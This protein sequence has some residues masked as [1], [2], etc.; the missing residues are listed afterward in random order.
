MQQSEQG[1]AITE[2]RGKKYWTD[3]RGSL[4]PDEVV[5]PADKLEDETVRKIIGHAADLSAQIER[6]KAHTMDDLAGLD[7]LLEQ[8]YGLVKKGNRGKGNR[9]YMTF[10]GLMRVTVQIADFVTFGPQLQVAKARIDECLN[11]WSSDAPAE[12][13]V[14]VTR[15]FN[16]DREGKVNRAEIYKLLRLDIADE[17][18]QQAMRAIKDAVRVIGRKEYVRF[19]VRERP[20]DGFVSITIDLAKA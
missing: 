20:E 7:A 11:E 2:V 15:A 10:D 14:V 16:T 5:K 12:L 3:S 19:A 1:A 4:V 9:T 13:R 17:R 8:D 18:W 6:F